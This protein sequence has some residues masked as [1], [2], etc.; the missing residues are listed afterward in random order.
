M[1]WCW[2]MK[3]MMEVATQ[4]VYANSG[5]LPAVRRHSST[6]KFITFDEIQ[7]KPVSGSHIFRFLLCRYHRKNETFVIP[8]FVLTMANKFILIFLILRQTYE[9]NEELNTQRL[10]DMFLCHH[11][12]LLWNIFVQIY[13]NA[14]MKLLIFVKGLRLFFWDRDYLMMWSK[15]KTDK[16]LIHHQQ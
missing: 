9:V 15:L 13:R 6:S 2:R 10:F 8:S 16:R 11:T 1:E 12:Q 3:A 4:V 7:R 5:G 14:S